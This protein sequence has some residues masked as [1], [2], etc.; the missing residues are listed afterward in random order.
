M[1]DKLVIDENDTD[2]KPV[3][4]AT[5]CSRHWRDSCFMH[6]DAEDVADHAANEAIGYRPSSRV[7][8]LRMAI[9]KIADEIQQ[10]EEDENDQVE[11]RRK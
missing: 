5:G 3:D 9:G 11:A 7:F 1:S 8:F 6:S 2:E 10:I 4:A